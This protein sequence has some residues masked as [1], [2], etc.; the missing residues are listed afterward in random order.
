MTNK[1]RN[2]ILR[3]DSFEII[4]TLEDDSID[5]LITDPPYNISRKTNFHTMHSSRWTSMNFWEWDKNFDITGWLELVIP[6]LKKWANIVIFNDWKNLWIL[7]DELRKLWCLVKRTLIYKKSNPVPFNRDRLF[8]NSM[9]FAIWAVKGKGWTFNRRADAGFKFE[10]WIFEYPCQRKTWHTTPKPLGLM[11]DLINILSNPGDIIL[12]PFAW[13]WTTAVAAQSL[14][15]KF[16]AIEKEKESYD[17]AKK[18]IEKEK[19]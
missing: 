5:Q 14:D 12:D 8:V 10:T 3:G 7:A 16:I 11:K 15:R 9:E 1:A 19:K 6:K 4:K 13:S 17:Y 2:M 18:R